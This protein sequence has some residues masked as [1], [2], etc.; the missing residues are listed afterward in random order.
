MSEFLNILDNN[1]NIK[2]TIKLEDIIDRVNISSTL[3]IVI[4]LADNKT[5]ILEFNNSTE[6]D[7][8]VLSLN[9]LM[10]DYQNRSLPD[11]AALTVI[12]GPAQVHVNNTYL[13]TLN[14][15]DLFNFNI[16]NNNNDTVGSIDINDNTK[17]IIGDS[18]ITINNLPFTNVF[19]ESSANIN[20]VNNNNDTVGG[21]DTN[22]NTKYIIG[23]STITVNNL[24]FTNVF[25][26]SSANINI[27]NSLNNNVGNII[28][29][30]I[31]ISDSII[32]FNNNPFISVPAEET[33]T[34][35]VINTSNDSIGASTL[36]P[37]EI[38]VGDSDVYINGNL[39]TSVSA[40]SSINIS[41]QNSTSQEVGS[42]VG[43]TF[44]VPSTT[45]T[46]GYNRPLNM[47]NVSY[48]VGDEGWYNAQNADP[49]VFDYNLEEM[50]ALDPTNWFKLA[51]N[52]SFGNK[53]RW[54]SRNGGYYDH[55]DF[56]YKDVNGNATT[57][58]AE[59]QENLTNI[60]GG[61]GGTGG[62]VVDNYTGLGFFTKNLG[63]LGVFSNFISTT[64]VN[65][66]SDTTNQFF[67]YTDWKLPSLSEALS[68]RDTS[69]SGARVSK[70]IFGGVIDSPYFDLRFDA[71]T[72][73]P[74]IYLQTDKNV[75]ILSA[76]FLT[77]SYTRGNNSTE[78][79]TL[80]R[81]HFGK[82]SILL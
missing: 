15:G 2:H 28:N 76:N 20:I 21:I 11:P 55:T 62:Y 72:I 60:F 47:Y 9:W 1:N 81:Y 10:S 18:I 82:N 38:L 46:M 48:T 58:E 45:K 41:V 64:L 69:V 5:V 44:V 54:T 7:N 17:Y 73:T 66:N 14:V 6:F 70:S 26:E 35:S 63:N 56:A 25:A 57:W 8:A 77:A 65:Y 22:D 79:I 43:N 67:N 59:F 42:K 31:V 33:K 34:L 53:Y 51:H 32:N 50:P 4:V 19:A 71:A 24:P 36:N 37:N 3:R 12:S 40:E 29:N 78:Q 39:F 30:N 49:Y 68:I 52:N 16:I 74:Y 23:D 13:A 80:V 61:I 27:I 75:K